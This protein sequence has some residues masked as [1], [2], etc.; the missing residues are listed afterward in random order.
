MLRRRSGVRE[1]IRRGIDVAV[2]CLCAPFLVPLIIMIAVIAKLDSPGP[3]FFR[4]RRLGYGG[5]PLLLLK[6]RTM[7]ADA[8]ELK[9]SLQHMSILPWPDFK[10][11]DDPRITRVGR[12]LRRTSLDELPQLWNIFRGDLTLVGPRP[13]RIPIEHYATW[14]TERLEARPG[15][16]GKWQCEGRARVNFEDRCRMDIRQ[17]RDRSVRRQLAFAYRTMMSVLAGRGAS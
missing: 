15:I 16:F 13:S 14:Q 3:A 2:V 4:D 17:V 12:W 10:I 7:V 11:P 5:R 6:F 9:V 1:P 8:E